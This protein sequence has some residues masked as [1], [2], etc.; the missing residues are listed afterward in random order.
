MIVEKSGTNRVEYSDT[1]LPVTLCSSSA[2]FPVSE[3]L[4]VAQASGKQSLIMA[5]GSG[6]GKQ[7]LAHSHITVVPDSLLVEV[8]F[9]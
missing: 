4:C 2:I 7:A 3:S 6:N 5:Y 8:G 9:N 1:G